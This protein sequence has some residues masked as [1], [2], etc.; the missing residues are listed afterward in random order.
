MNVIETLVER[1]DEFVETRFASGLPILP[2]LR[3]LGSAAWTRASTAHTCLVST[4]VTS[5]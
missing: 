3:T 5:R 4:S 1:N 2:R